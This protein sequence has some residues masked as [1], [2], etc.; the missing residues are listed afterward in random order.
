MDYHFQQFLEPVTNP[1][2]TL[3]LRDKTSKS[4]STKHVRNY[5]RTMIGYDANNPSTLET[6]K[7]DFIVLSNALKQCGANKEAM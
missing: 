4:L 7:S 3:E 5:T 6:G 1:I 2:I